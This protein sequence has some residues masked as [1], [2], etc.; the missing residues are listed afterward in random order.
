MVEPLIS[1]IV[2]IYNV[3]KYLDKCIMSIV[4]QTYKNLEIILVDDGSLDNCPSICDK[5]K[6]LDN[7]IIVVHKENGGL[8]DARNKGLDMA[9]GEYISFID[10]DDF[11]S[12]YFIEVLY[13]NLINTRSDL[14]QCSHLKVN[15][16]YLNKEKLISTDLHIMVFN[17]KN[18]L[19]SL[20]E[21]K[22]LNQIVWNK[23]YKKELLQEMRFE[24]D[25]LNEDDFFSYQ[26]F[27]KCDKIAYIDL[28]LYY[29][30]MR[31]ESI[32]G[33]QYSIKRLDGLEARFI[34]YKFLK[35]NY[36]EL[37]PLA[38][39][40]LIFFI[41]YCYQMVLTIND[42]KEKKQAE[43]ITRDYFKKIIND[44]IAMEL[45]FKEKIWIIMMKISIKWTA[46][47]RNKLK[48]NVN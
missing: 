6:N 32:M 47:L 11:I 33:K 41:I 12:K 34:R 44:N 43:K 1:V 22:N 48:I 29:Y 37:G 18:A 17:T 38:K 15:S 26:I 45:N 42:K 16:D 31:N 4:S 21:E 19:E 35:K 40:N 25:K 3:E 39:K 36:Y 24:Y 27:A 30:F 10:S 20:I 8:S 14:I 13:K 7:R 28:P 46:I 9:T 2:P 23:L 5:W